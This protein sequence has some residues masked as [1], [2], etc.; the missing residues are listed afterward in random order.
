MNSSSTASSSRSAFDPALIEKE[1]AHLKKRQ[2]TRHAGQEKRTWSKVIVAAGVLGLIGL[3][4]MDALIFSYDRGDAIRVY[5]YLHNYGSDAKA[6]AVADCGLLT[7]KEVKRLNAREGSFQ[8]FYAGTRAA[9]AR[10]D[11]LIATMEEVDAL[12]HGHYDLL[13]PLNKLRYV[14]FIKTG[15]TPPTHWTALDSSIDK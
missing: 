9:E 4:V 7:D 3:W 6:D 13:S 12:H 10:A 11:E 2:G 14:L 8:D 1:I 5:L 15:L